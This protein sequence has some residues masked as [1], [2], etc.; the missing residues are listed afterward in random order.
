MYIGKREKSGF[1]PLLVPERKNVVWMKD[2]VQEFT[3]PG[4]LVVD[5]CAGIFSVA[6]A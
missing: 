4:N 1:K 3:K 5:V 6:K 2:I